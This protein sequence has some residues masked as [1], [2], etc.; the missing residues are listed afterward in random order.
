VSG[1]QKCSSVYWNW[2]VDETVTNNVGNCLGGE[3]CCEYEWTSCNYCKYGKCSTYNCVSKC[4]QT[5]SISLCSYKCVTNKYYLYYYTYLC[6]DGLNYF[7]N[8]TMVVDDNEEIHKKGNVIVL[9]S[10]LHDNR[11]RMLLNSKMFMGCVCLFMI[12]FVFSVIPIKECM[13]ILGLH[14][15]NR[16]GFSVSTVFPVNV[17]LPV[18]DV[19]SSSPFQLRVVEGGVDEEKTF[20]KN[21]ETERSINTNEHTV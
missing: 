8:E 11:M 10:C 17:P 9:S 3:I 1:T 14:H 7:V 13:S 6:D 4:T 16:D 5:M 15:Y 20:D 12:V 21:N 18:V 19:N 2:T